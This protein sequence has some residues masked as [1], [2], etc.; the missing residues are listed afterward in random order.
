VN[1]HFNQMFYRCSC[2]TSTATL[3]SSARLHVQRAARAM[4]TALMA[5]KALK[6]VARYSQS[7]AFNHPTPVPA[8]RP[9]PSLH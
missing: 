2:S 1:G 7:A 5:G 4:S 8:T 9:S 3:P 6:P